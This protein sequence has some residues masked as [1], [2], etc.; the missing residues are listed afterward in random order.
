MQRM[1]RV[2]RQRT[3]SLRQMIIKPLSKKSVFNP[4]CDSKCKD[5]AH[6][7]INFKQMTELHVICSFENKYSAAC[8]FK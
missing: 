4:L 3:Y 8:R 5:C 2:R 1:S 7:I 6:I